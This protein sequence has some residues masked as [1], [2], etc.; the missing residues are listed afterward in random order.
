MACT[1]LQGQRQRPRAGQ[2]PGE[3]PGEGSSTRVGTRR[4]GRSATSCGS[5]PRPPSS[6][7][8]GFVPFPGERHHH[9]QDHHVHRAA[10]R[11]ALAAA[12]YH[13]PL[14]LGTHGR[15]LGHG[16]PTPE[17]S[18]ALA[19]SEARWRSSSRSSSSCFAILAALVVDLGHR[20]R[21]SSCLAERLRCG[22]PRRAPTGLFPD[23]QDLRLREPCPVTPTPSRAV[24]QY[25]DLNFD[26]ASGDWSSC[27]NPGK[28]AYVVPGE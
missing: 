8:T 10:R 12:G 28:L 25:A 14:G 7:T 6:S 23:Q 3:E 17:Q 27:S 11:P 24:K 4:R 5:A 15:Q 1:A 2:P 22:G 26:V 19:T 20:P 9:E 13:L 18:G 21:H 16:P